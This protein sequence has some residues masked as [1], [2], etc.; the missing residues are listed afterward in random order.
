[1]LPVYA[2][3]LN[4]Q[5][6]D[7]HEAGERQVTIVLG[8]ANEPTYG[9]KPG[10]H[11]G[12]HGVEVFL[13]DSATSL[14][15]AGSSLKVDK[16]YF[17]GFRTF[18]RAKSVND[19]T[20]I[21]KRVTL[22]EVFGDPGHYIARQVQKDGIYGYRLYGTVNY[23]AVEELKIDTTVFCSS[24]DGDTDKFNSPGWFGGFGCTER[25]DEILFPT[26]NSSVNSGQGRVT[27]EVPATN[28][29]TIQQASTTV[30]AGSTSNIAVAETSSTATQLLMIAGIPI[31]AAV[32]I[33]GI[34]SVRHNRR[35]KE[36]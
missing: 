33:F 14:P 21:Q 27:F 29:A 1:M 5:E 36:L 4:I 26:K 2:H 6:L 22:A 10:I 11:D 19:A 25:I 13:E 7:V 16:Y 30:P 32:G 8:H 34:R 20:E 18:N 24:T 23:F 35:L 17:N 3:S 28:G 31:A 15:L 9:V 12:K